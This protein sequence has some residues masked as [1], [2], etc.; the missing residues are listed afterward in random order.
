MGSEIEVPGVARVRLPI[1]F[2]ISH[3]FRSAPRMF[4]TDRQTDEIGLAKGGTMH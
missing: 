3:R 1:G 2:P 4:Q